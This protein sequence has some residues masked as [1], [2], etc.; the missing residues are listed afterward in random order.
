MLRWFEHQAISW[1]VLFRFTLVSQV[2]VRLCTG[3][4][5]RLSILS[6]AMGGIIWTS[7]HTAGLV[8]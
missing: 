3:S 7:G 4:G 2:T 5:F 8:P 6:G 1:L